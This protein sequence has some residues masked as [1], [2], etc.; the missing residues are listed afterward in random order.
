MIRNNRPYTN[1]NGYIDGG[2][3]TDHR[4]EDILAVSEW[5]KENLEPCGYVMAN[6]TSYGLKHLLEG[7]TGI[8]LTNNEFKDA[9]WLAGFRPI[10]ENALNW[11]YRMRFRV[12][13]NSNPF[14]KWAIERYAHGNCHL[15][16]FVLGMMRDE[17]FPVF[18]DK[19]VILSYLTYLGACDEAL[20]CL[21]NMWEEY[22][23]EGN[24]K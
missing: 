8:Y 5:I 13:S 9:L 17:T 14:F 24:G 1:E 19:D 12:A 16:D 23:R 2:L 11:K 20:M 21:E 15:S 4:I 18:A 3:I 7:D 10:D 6:K 22:E